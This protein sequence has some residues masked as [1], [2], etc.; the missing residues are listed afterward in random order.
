[1]AKG[2]PKWKLESQNPATGAGLNSNQ[3]ECGRDWMLISAYTHI[4]NLLPQKNHGMFQ[5]S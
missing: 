5:T 2:M 1:M 3:Y 4:P